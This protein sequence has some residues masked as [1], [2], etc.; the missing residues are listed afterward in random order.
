MSSLDKNNSRTNHVL[1]RIID[2]G[3]QI[4]AVK[5]A[6][7]AWAYLLAHSIEPTTILR[8]LSSASQRRDSRKA[9]AACGSAAQR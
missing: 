4:D 5:G 9:L 8:V 2:E 7:N 3:I 1:E 6:A